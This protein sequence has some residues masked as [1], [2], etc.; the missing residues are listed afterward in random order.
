MG[1][2]QDGLLILAALLAFLLGS[3]PFAV[4]A[5]RVFAGID[6]RQFG[7]GNPGASNTFRILGPVPGTVVLLLDAG[8]GAAGV[9]LGALA[10][11]HGNAEF[12]AYFTTLCGL[13][14][15]LGHI[16]S[17]WL[18]FRGGKGV[19]PL[20]GV[21]AMLFPWGTLA[22]AGS[23]GLVIVAF[24]KFSLGS[25]AG[26]VALPAFFFILHR[27]PLSADAR[28]LLLLIGVAFLIVIVR[29]LGNFRRLLRGEEHGLRHQDQ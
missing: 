26:A 1:W 13:C 28:P 5:G 20:L 6:I 9:A 19:G 18:G 3:T 21:F 16:W 10:Q 12:T 27:A 2:L 8:K 29:H 22:A 25:L 24:R 11:G 7:S 14:A 4:L 17:P 23:A 15:V